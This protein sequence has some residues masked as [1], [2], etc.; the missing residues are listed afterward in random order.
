MNLNAVALFAKVVEYKS[1]SKASEKSGVS[2]SS[3]SRKISELEANLNVKLLERTTR[4]LRLTNEG[5]IF[6]EKIQPAIYALNSA[7]LDLLDD[8]SQSKGT[9]RISVPPGLEDSLI[10]P[11]LADFKKQYPEVRLKLIATPANLKFVEDG[12]DIALRIGNLNDSNNIARTVLTYNHILVASP[13]Y[14]KNNPIQGNDKQVPP[15]LDNQK[16][17][18]AA[19]WNDNIQWQLSNGKSKH[20]INIKE[21]LSFNHY[22]AI[23]LAAEKGMGIAELPS[24]NC[25]ES[26]KKGSLIQILPDWKL[27]VYG[28]DEIKLSIVYTANRYNS[29]L[30]QNFKVFSLDFFK[31]KQE[32]INNIMNY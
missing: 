18:C 12:I 20:T 16:L 14:L 24:I 6:F 8:S 15:L 10:I 28:E 2:T 17:L 27:S 21:S 13:D 1:F 9:L 11:L 29:I 32:Q 30:I 31:S 4:T 19:N 25:I 23:Q 7:R 26:I 3:M 22:V 5:A